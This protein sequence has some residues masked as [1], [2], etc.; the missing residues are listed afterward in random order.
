MYYQNKLENTNLYFVCIKIVIKK[1][2]LYRLFL[3][4]YM[5]IKQIWIIKKYII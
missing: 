1:K 5:N 4:I 2:L 3:C